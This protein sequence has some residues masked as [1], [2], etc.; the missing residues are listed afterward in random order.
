M[1]SRFATPAQMLYKDSRPHACPRVLYPS[2]I[3]HEFL[4]RTRSTASGAR[5]LLVR[6]ALHHSLCHGGFLGN[7]SLDANPG[8]MC[9][10]S[11]RGSLG[12][13]GPLLGVL[14]RRR[15]RIGEN[16][17]VMCV[18]F[19]P[20]ASRRGLPTQDHLAPPLRVRPETPWPL[21]VKNVHAPLLFEAVFV[22][23]CASP[24][25][26]VVMLHV[27]GHSIA[28][29]D[30][31]MGLDMRASEVVVLLQLHFL[32]EADRRANVHHEEISENEMFPAE[33]FA[34]EGPCA[35]PQHIDASEFR[36]LGLRCTAQLGKNELRRR[37]GR[38]DKAPRRRM[39]L[40]LRLIRPLARIL[41]VPVLPCR[42][43]VR[44]LNA[45]FALRLCVL[46]RLVPCGSQLPP[47][48]SHEA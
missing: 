30:G 44:E 47:G 13:S 19:A 20:V 28:P 8:R 33:S 39:G 27:E 43:I 37:D 14:A 24:A 3:L 10:A 12:N 36:L 29:H 11:Q 38:H 41:A 21:L 34:T 22:A 17:V 25:A 42:N 6:R 31:A 35:T 1:A 15:T 46:Q 16:I 32:V 26:I 7:G 9:R 5:K 23:I 40:V 4:H 48:D 45:N 18:F 2:L